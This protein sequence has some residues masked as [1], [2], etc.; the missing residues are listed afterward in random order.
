MWI[1]QQGFSDAELDRFRA[2][3][4]LSFAIL[5]ETAAGL[6]EGCT[7]QE[8]GRALV[9]R[10]RAEGVRSFFHLPV[11]LFGER[12]AL[13][14]RWTLGKFYPRPSALAPGD[15]VILDA[16]PLFGG[17]LVDTSYSFC[18]GENEAHRRMMR[19][20]SVFR[21]GVCAAVNAGRRFAAI[22]DDVAGELEAKGYEP[23]HTKH[24]GAVLGH[25]ALKTPDLPFA[26]RLRGFDAAS[27]GWFV[28]MGR[29]AS[30]GLVAGAPTWNQT[31]TSDHAP[32]DGLWL[33]E[34]HAG[35]EEVGAKWEE[36]L[37]VSGGRAHWLDDDTPNV[38]QWRRIE[39]G[40]PYGPE[41]PGAA[42]RAS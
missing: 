33:V 35:K 37:V 25:R 21:D 31:R 39:A 3:Q 32:L 42:E 16:S 36:I 10:Y 19:D 5:E 23:V 22:A 17:Y 26:W 41:P 9:R 27:L 34:P 18:F 15:A 1:R 13:P 6:A 24:P 20:L 40:L 30:A 11:V 38:R 2:L 4:R 7:E 12:T 8:V 14:G 29:A 28:A